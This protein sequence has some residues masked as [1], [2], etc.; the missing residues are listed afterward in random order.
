MRNAVDL[1]RDLHSPRAIV[2]AGGLKSATEDNIRVVRQK[3]GGTEPTEI[4]YNFKEIS[5]GKAP[6]PLLEANDIVAISQDK[7]QSIINNIGRS[8][9]GGLPSIFYRIP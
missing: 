8:L 4:V 7:T 9:T 6:D 5:K 1:G 3:P 2:L